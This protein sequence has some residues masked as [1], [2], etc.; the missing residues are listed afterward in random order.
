MT[1][2]L[3]TNP[4]VPQRSNEWLRALARAVPGFPAVFVGLTA[5]EWVEAQ[6]RARGDEYFVYFVVALFVY[7][8]VDVVWDRLLRRLAPGWSNY[9]P[10][11]DR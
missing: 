5:K 3:P 11:N 4:G 10:P 1:S 9:Q 7:I 8:V 6:G 2:S